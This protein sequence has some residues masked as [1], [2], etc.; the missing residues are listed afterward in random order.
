MIILAIDPGTT[1]SAWVLY[2]D[3]TQQLLGY[4]KQANEDVLEVIA[5][6]DYAA[7]VIERIESYGMPVGREVFAT[8]QWTGRFIAAIENVGHPWYELPR[9]Q[10]KSHL[11]HSGKAR[12]ANVRQALLD[13]FSGPTTPSGNPAKG[14]PLK[15]VT[16]DVWAALAV[17]VTWTDQRPTRRWADDPDE[18]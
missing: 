1:K 13:R 14:H 10:V 12:D 5:R 16:G 9:L 17:A 4:G 11:C 8:V 2:S 6:E 18:R 15:G 7:A 3:A